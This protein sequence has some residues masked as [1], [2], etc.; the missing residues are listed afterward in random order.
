MTP[1]QIDRKSFQTHRD[2]LTLHPSIKT[3]TSYYDHE[4][5]EYII[6][7]HLEKESIKYI[8]TVEGLI[9]KND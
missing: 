7:A 9:R 4:S 1:K 8:L 2:L 5:G 6:I 3:T